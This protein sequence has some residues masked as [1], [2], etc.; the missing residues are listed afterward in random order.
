M[1]K[2][3]VLPVPVLAWPMMSCPDRATG[4]VIAWMGNGA[5]MPASLE[6]VDDLGVYPEVCEGS[7]VLRSR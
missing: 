2:P 4:R 5:M 6:R 1:P 3:R 7:Q